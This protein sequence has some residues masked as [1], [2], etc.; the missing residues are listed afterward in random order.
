LIK[1][2]SDKNS[3]TEKTSPDGVTLSN[4][5]KGRMCVV[6]G[7]IATGIL[8]QRMMDLGILTG[9]GITVTGTAPLGDPMII[10]IEGSKIAIR[11]ADARGIFVRYI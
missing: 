11:K 6:E 7:I 8:R 3:S 2:E 5:K 1:F 4:V 10:E 9:T